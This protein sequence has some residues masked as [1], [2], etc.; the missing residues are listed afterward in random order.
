MVTSHILSHTHKDIQEGSQSTYK[1]S[2]EVVHELRGTMGTACTLGETYQRI[3]QPD[4]SIDYHGIPSEQLDNSWLG[5]IASRI[6]A[7]SSNFQADYLVLNSAQ[8]NT[9]QSHV[10][11][12]DS[13]FHLTYILPTQLP[14]VTT[15]A[16]KHQ[17]ILP[18]VE[19]PND[20]HA[21]TS[22]VSFALFTWF[23]QY[24]RPFLPAYSNHLDT[25][26]HN[27]NPTAPPEHIYANASLPSPLTLL[28]DACGIRRQITRIGDEESASDSDLPHKT[29]LE[30]ELEITLRSLPTPL[31][32][33]SHLFGPTPSNSHPVDHRGYTTNPSPDSDSINSTTMEES[34]LFELCS[35]VSSDLG[36]DSDH[37]DYP[38]PHSNPTTY[39]MAI[40][41]HN[42]YNLRFTLDFNP[43]QV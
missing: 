12:V 14:Y 7:P 9:L 8:Y 4:P 24:G 29:P 18:M 40:G 19:L 22:P 23:G 3:F 43:N 41:H 39:A 32:E 38:P 13:H 34:D 26:L 37:S 1:P 31:N 11:R 2:I 36:W 30:R 20:A 42:P 35:E 25:T 16:D 33:C 15:E 21:I 27:A 5:L 28:A 6:H 10:C 17:I